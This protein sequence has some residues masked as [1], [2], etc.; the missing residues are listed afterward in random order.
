M[1]KFLLTLPVLKRLVPSIL[2]K[3]SFKEISYKYDD[4]HFNLDLRYLVDRRFFLYGY[5][6]KNIEILNKYIQ[7]YE[8]GYFLDIGSCWG[9]YSLQIAKKNPRIR[10]LSFDVFEQN[11]NRIKKMSLKNNVQNIETYN[12]A[13]GSEES[14]VEF[15]V[16]EEFSPNYSKDLNGKFK[17]KVEQKKIDTILDIKH[18]KIA[19]KIDVE[20]HEFKVLEG[21]SKLFRQNE[22]LLQ[23]ELFKER[24]Q[25]IISY[26]RDKNFQ[27]INTIEKDFYFKNF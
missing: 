4:I 10:V 22:I 15:S 19:I 3:L 20:R 27:H 18:Q 17:I 8:T 25:K 13:V 7:N 12:I 5:D 9:L 24:Q 21:L 1:L 6:A 23:I 26:L 11:I 16:D 2:K 14:E